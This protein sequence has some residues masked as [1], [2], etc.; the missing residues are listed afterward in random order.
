MIEDAR[1]TQAPSR[2]RLRAFLHSTFLN[3]TRNLKPGIN[4]HLSSIANYCTNNM[5]DLMLERWIQYSVGYANP[6]SAVGAVEKTAGSTLENA[7]SFR[8]FV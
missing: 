7:K 6:K 8:F 1:P 5:C 4:L 2:F 3:R